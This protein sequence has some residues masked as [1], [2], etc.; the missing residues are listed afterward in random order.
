M[1][2][3]F[4]I[5]LV[6]DLPTNLHTLS[7]ILSDTYDLRV[8]TSGLDALRIAEA[9]APD[10]ILLDIMMP[11][12]DGFET[13]IHLRHTEW[14]REIPVILVTADDRMESQVKGL[15]LG[16]EDFIAKPILAP[17]LKARVHNVLERLRLHRELVRLAT[18]DELTG[19]MNRRQ[20]YARAESHWRLLKRYPAPCGLLMVDL[21]KFKRINDS[22]GHAVGDEVL[23]AFAN[24]IRQGLRE[25]DLFGRVGG[26]EFAL[27]L[28]QTGT[29]ACVDV[30]ERLRLALAA[31]A[32]KLQD[33]TVIHFTASFGCTQLRGED[34]SLDAAMS[35]AD[36]AL[37]GAKT[38]GR[39]QTQLL[40]VPA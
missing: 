7:Q 15:E 13:L 21:D 18:T 2:Q 29:Q 8:A 12:M 16:A 4:S 3:T 23:K 1:Q 28:P 6:D 11:Q 31:F 17:V 24:T 33:G 9:Q 19:V 37:Y 40:L 27:L 32:L 34:S 35:R 5:L 10:L 25:H 30:A 14:G 26:E 20:F 39:N 38:G 36:R 22:H